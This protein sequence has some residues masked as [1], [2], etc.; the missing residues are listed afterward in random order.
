MGRDAQP[1]NGNL[2]DRGNDRTVTGDPDTNPATASPVVTTP[3]PVSAPTIDHNLAPPPPTGTPTADPT[4]ASDTASPAERSSYVEAGGARRPRNVY[5][6]EA[7]DAWANNAYDHIRST[8]NDIDGMVAALADVQRHDGSVGFDRA[9]LERIKDHLF[10]EE[11]PL[12]IT[13]DDGNDVGIEYRRYDAYAD[14]AEA[15]MRMSLG[16]ATPDD[17]VLLEHEL[18]EAQYY[19]SHPGA[20]YQEAHQFANLSFNWEAMQHSRTGENIDEWSSI[21]GNVSGL[22]TGVGDRPGSDV[23]VRRGGSQSQSV[24]DN[25]QSGLLGEGRGREGGRDGRANSGHSDDSSPAGRSLDQGGQLPSLNNPLPRQSGGHSSAS[26]QPPNSPSSPPAPSPDSAPHQRP[27]AVPPATD[28]T[29]AATAPSTNPVVR[30][31]TDTGAEQSPRPTPQTSPTPQQVHEANQSR[32]ARENL[33]RQRP[34]GGVRPVTD[35]RGNR[36][37]TLGR[38]TTAFSQPVSMLR[39]GLHISG[40]GSLDPALVQAL[41]E[42]AQ[43]AVDLRFNRGS[44]LPSGDWM[45]FD[46][47]PVSDPSAADMSID[48]DQANPH[49]TPTDADLD[50]LTAMLREQLGLD[51]A[52]ENELS[53]S[54]VQRINN[55]IDQAVPTS[56]PTSSRTAPGPVTTDSSLDLPSQPANLANRADSPVSALNAASPHPNSA[57]TASPDQSHAQH[58]PTP[59]NSRTQIPS[60]A[61]NHRAP[62]STPPPT[63][64]PGSMSSTGASNSS[65][66]WN[67]PD[68]TPQTPQ[69]HQSWGAAPHPDQRSPGAM[70]RIVR[71]LFGVRPRRSIPAMPPPTPP[72]QRP[73]S[74]APRTPPEES[75][76]RQSTAPQDFSDLP[77]SVGPPYTTQE[78]NST[79]RGEHEVGNSVWPHP[80][81]VAYLDES[82]RQRTRLYIVDGKIYTAD[83]KLFDTSSGTTAWGGA[84]RAIFVMDEHGNLYASNYHEPGLFHHSSFLS[85]GNVAAAGELAVIGG[86]LQML[87]DSSGHYRPSRGHTMQAINLLRNMGIPITP[88]QVHFEAPPQ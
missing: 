86:E 85:G 6:T 11:H 58:A 71:K 79:Y 70:R 15:W 78:M 41:I 66:G 76:P 25:Q 17:I 54:D 1:D 40:G 7:Q 19:E 43:F 14:I 52:T 2:A 65:S 72:I 74:A 46:L 82:L 47:V 13:D 26:D 35:S 9:E 67:N 22:P 36:R 42:R 62:E 45:M 81:R 49:S 28:R 39:I 55:E 80:L 37:F 50:T 63:N 38:F 88:G 33:R 64:P 84:G 3:P 53:P 69:W 48:L 60:R 59:A 61:P 30:P 16:R 34:D 83:G 8:D 18:A 75:S 57:R 29:G 51:P 24:P 56:P 20:P 23:P 77:Y 5:D 21:Y 68:V 12:S 27:A 73:P 31:P 44:R 4:P 87:T 32:A 10:R